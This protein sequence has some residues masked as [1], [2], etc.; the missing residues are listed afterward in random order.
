LNVFN[1]SLCNLVAGT[2]ICI[3]LWAFFDIYYLLAQYCIVA[4][5]LDFS[6]QKDF[7]HL[8]LCSFCFWTVMTT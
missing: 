8:Q 3:P 4:N 2:A 5:R 1:V 6:V 7:L